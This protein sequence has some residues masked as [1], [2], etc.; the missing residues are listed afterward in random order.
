[1]ALIVILSARLANAKNSLRRLSATNCCLET[2]GD[3]WKHSSVIPLV[4]YSVT[5]PSHGT[6]A[7]AQVIVPRQICTGELNPGCRDT[8]PIRHTH[9]TRAPQPQN[10]RRRKT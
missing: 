3:Y 4:K 2:A 8:K 6:R 9:A 1:M 5:A 10:D 7:Q